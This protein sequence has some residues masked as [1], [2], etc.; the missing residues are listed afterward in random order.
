[1][2]STLSGRSRGERGAAMIEYAL[3]VGLIAV[4]AVVGVAFLGTSVS[5]LFT[6]ANSCLST[7]GDTSTQSGTSQLSIAN[8][9]MSNQLGSGNQLSTG[10]RINS[11]TT[12][13]DASAC[14]ATA[15][16]GNQNLQQNQQQV[17]QLLH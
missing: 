7:T 11:G 5:N 17:L 2:R 10:Q 3:L 1:M 15:N 16:N 12:A 4:V 13:P 6:H 9:Q 8:S 14:A